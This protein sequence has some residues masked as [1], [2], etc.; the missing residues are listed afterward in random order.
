MLQ[1]GDNVIVMMVLRNVDRGREANI[2]EQIGMKRSALLVL[3]V[4]PHYVP[5]QWDE[6]GRSAI[7]E[8]EDSVA[9]IR[10]PKNIKT[11]WMHE[12][13]KDL[14]ERER[15]VYVPKLVCTILRNGFQVVQFASW[16]CESA[17]N[18][19]LHMKPRRSM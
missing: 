17:F 1:W 19:L 18:A 2:V 6:N 4:R 12:L 14:V 10:S 11:P 9:V 13:Y 7:H 16:S 3:P 5:M 8:Y 15:Q